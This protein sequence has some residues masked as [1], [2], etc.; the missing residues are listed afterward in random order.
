[1]V[2]VFRGWLGIPALSAMWMA[3]AA[4]V[5]AESIAMV[6]DLSG[7]AVVQGRSA[8]ILT[9]IEA[10][11]HVQLD[12][13]A[14]LV[15]IYLKS[16]DEYSFTGPA[17]IQFRANEPQILSGAK[18]QKRANPLAKGA[19]DIAIKPVGVT[20]AAF[21]MRGSRAT[22]RIKLLS[23]SGTKTVEV[24]PEFR[25]QEVEPDLKYQFDLTDETGKALIETQVEGASY[26]LPAS[27]QLR[28]GTAYT[29]E[30]SARL[31]DGRRYV[32]VG[33]FSIAPAELRARVNTLRPAI[34]APVSDRVTYAAWLEQMELRDEALKYWRVL[35][36]ERP[37]DSKLKSLAG[38]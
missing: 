12:A 29:W 9:E 19:K 21:V 38:E 4:P 7:K 10:D 8:T 13:G 30:V 31:R 2:K 26:R 15:A 25:W 1:M 5:C 16:G 33:D 6:T 23:L 36:A 32:S 20:Q 14:R 22:A 3:F 11:A 18:P 27:V 34:G 28:P 35:A 17:Q 37:D 24:S